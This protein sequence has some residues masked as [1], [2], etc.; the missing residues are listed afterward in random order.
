MIIMLRDK[1]V[2]GGLKSYEHG[3]NQIRLRFLYWLHEN[4]EYYNNK[5]K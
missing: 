3:L 4:Y 1:I 2:K 5:V